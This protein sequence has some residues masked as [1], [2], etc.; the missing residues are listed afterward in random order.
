M[1]AIDVRFLQRSGSLLM[2]GLAL[3]PGVALA[4]DGNDA[5][6]ALARYRQERAVCNSGR[7]NQDRATCLKEAGAA[8]AEARRGAL[9]AGDGDRYADNA[10]ERCKPL[11]EADRKDCMARIE[12]GTQ[13]G[14]V[15]GGGILR[16]LVTREAAPTDAA[17]AASAA[18]R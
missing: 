16:E 14:S 17:P 1:N 15:S 6:G 8:L 12:Q 10:L 11:P 9:G 7:S 3:A 13:S 5:A 2:L 4:A 18:P